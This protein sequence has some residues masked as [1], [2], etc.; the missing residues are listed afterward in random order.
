MNEGVVHNSVQNRPTYI[1]IFVF[2]NI[3]VLHAI[4]LIPA[5]CCPLVSSDETT[6]QVPGMSIKIDGP[7]VVD[8]LMRRY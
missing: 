3:D 7:D 1:Y 6:K 4:Q 8:V 2:Q 5:L